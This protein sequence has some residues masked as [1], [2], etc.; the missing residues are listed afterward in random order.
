MGYRL[1]RSL[2]LKP[3]HPEYTVWNTSPTCCA[4]NNS[5]SNYKACDWRDKLFSGTYAP[6]CLGCGEEELRTVGVGAG[7]GHGQIPCNRNR[8]SSPH[9]LSYISEGNSQ[10]PS[11]PPTPPP[12][13]PPCRQLYKTFVV[14]V[15]SNCISSKCK[16]YLSEGRCGNIHISLLVSKLSSVSSFF[17]VYCFASQVLLCCVL[18][19][20][21]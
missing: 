16:R 8:D 18:C 1:S 17:V 14:I 11:C 10:Q 4:C 13:Q 7:V 15:S 21:P 6:V 20:S 12:P 3:L 19:L 5:T 2:N 9:I